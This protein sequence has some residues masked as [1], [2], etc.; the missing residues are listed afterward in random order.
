MGELQLAIEQNCYS[1][2]ETVDFDGFNMLSFSRRKPS[3]MIQFPRNSHI[4]PSVELVFFLI[5]ANAN[6]AQ[7]GPILNINLSGDYEV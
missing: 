7:G 6:V 1:N 4:I 2:C 5:R 3:T